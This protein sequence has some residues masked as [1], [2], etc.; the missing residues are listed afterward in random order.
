MLELDQ[1]SV[2][3]HPGTPGE[4]RALRDV[5]LRAPSGQFVTVVGA[6]GSGKSTLV[7]V[8]AGAVAPCA[9][10]VRIDGADVTGE[11]VHR[12]AARVAR[13]F[14]DPR[15]GSAPELSVEENLALA[16]ARGRRRGVRRAVTDRRRH[17]MRD[18]LAVLG[19]GLED[20]LDQ[21]V[22]LLS[23]GQRQSLTM[24][25]ATLRHPSVLLL[26]EHLAALD[27]AT[28]RRVLLLTT[29]LAREA[30]STTVM[31]THDMHA[32]LTTG[33]RLVVVRAGRIGADLSGSELA[34]LD[35]ATLTELLHDPGPGPT[36]RRRVAS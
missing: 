22:G 8:L 34:R 6:N 2:T 4:V 27:P 29:D 12:R 20:R 3:Y 16:M 1:V 26:D 5:C 19:L 13:V 9:G 15:A 24:V 28:A 11:A 23:A 36:E 30:G 14:D 17:R 31:V 25:M 21:P 33:D 35:A 18:A 32:A 10:R 7:G